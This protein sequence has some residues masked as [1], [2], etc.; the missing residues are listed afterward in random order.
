MKALN[1]VVLVAF[2]LLAGGC[3]TMDGLGK[4]LR[5]LGDTI[6]GKAEQKK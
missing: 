4:D 5:A 1:A 3:N 6:S 2:A